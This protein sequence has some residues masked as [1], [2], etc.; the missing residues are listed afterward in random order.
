MIRKEQINTEIKIGKVIV[1]ETGN[2]LI[3]EYDKDE[4]LIDEITIDDLLEIFTDRRY[5]RI[6]IDYLRDI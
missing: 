5:V 6:R 2:Y 4:N 3:E 1:D